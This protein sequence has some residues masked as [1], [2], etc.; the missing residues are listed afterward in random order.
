MTEPRTYRIVAAGETVD[1][2]RTAECAGHSADENA[3]G[4]LEDYS[5]HHGGLLTLEYVDAAVDCSTP[6]AEARFGAAVP[7][8]DPDALASDAMHCGPNI[9]AVPEHAHDELH[10]RAS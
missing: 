10:R 9:A 4:N 2:F 5:F 1:L 6:I 3:V 8:V 7:L